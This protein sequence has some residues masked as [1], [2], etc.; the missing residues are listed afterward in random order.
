MVPAKLLRLA[1]DIVEVPEEPAWKLRLDGLLEMLKSGG[2]TTLAVTITE[3]ER[4]PR[5]PF[6]VTGKF[7]WLDETIG[8]VKDPP[9][10]KLEPRL[11]GRERRVSTKGSRS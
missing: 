9:P 3:C 5:S 2:T 10:Q 7:P 6:T 8:G 11:V 1:S 4:D